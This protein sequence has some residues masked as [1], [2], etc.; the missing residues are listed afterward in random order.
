MSRWLPVVAAVLAS[1][2][3]LPRA[4]TAQHAAHM[5]EDAA[6]FRQALGPVY[7]NAIVRDAGGPPIPLR[8]QTDS[9]GVDALVGNPLLVSDETVGFDRRLAAALLGSGPL[10]EAFAALG[11]RLPETNLGVEVFETPEGAILVTRIG[12]PNASVAL[13]PGISR[14]REI[15]IVG[16]GVAW[17]ARIP[18]YTDLASGWYPGRVDVSVDGVPSLSVVITDLGP[19]S[20]NLAPLDAS[21]PGDGAGPALV[22]P[23]LPL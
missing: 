1:T 3:M 13:E 21:A 22:F 16:G 15:R 8:F 9:G 7:G 5:L 20:A 17:I 10:G 2:L 12:S 14:P 23:R 11:F 18:A 19:S 6:E 4:A